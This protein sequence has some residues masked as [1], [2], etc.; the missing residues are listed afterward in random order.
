MSQVT[1]Y[2]VENAAGNVVR[3]DINNILDAIRTSN[4][5]SSDPSNPVKFML[6]GDSS[7]DILKVYDGSAFRNI[8]DVGEDNLG[9]LPRS[10]GTMTGVILADDA[11]GASTPAI[12]FDGDPDTG[13]FRKSANTIGLSTAGT[14]RAVIDS[15][16]LTVQARGDLRLAD[17][18]SSNW[19][20]LQAASA[21]G[22]NVTFTLPSADGSDGQMLKTNG[23]G[24][25][26]FTTVQGVPTGAV[27]CLAVS[28]VP[29]DYLECNGAAVSR[30]TYAALF[31]VITTTYGAGNGSTT[32]NLPDLRGEFV[33]GWDHGR[34]VDSERSIATSQGSQFAQHK[35]S[36]GTLNVANKSLTGTATDISETFQV[37]ST[38]GIFGKGA[39]GTGPLTPSSADTSVTGTLTINASHDHSISGNT[40]NKGG[41]TA[42]NENRPRNITM[43]YIIKI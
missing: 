33:R 29:A 22:S 38:S 37:G 24:T 43:M 42:P 26:S 11:S 34:G 41:E 5:G 17:S 16:G 1:N 15:N 35:H 30:S 6:Y 20:A 8:G 12:A 27:F 28:A 2:N 9:L 3:Q 25:L 10:G 4:S 23:S 21:I 32:F 39:N 19:V 31:A 13:L 40:E 7:D 36:A 14:E 18:D